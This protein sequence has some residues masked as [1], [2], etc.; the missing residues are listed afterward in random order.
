MQTRETEND[1]QGP[2]CYRNFEK[3]APG[4]Q[5]GTYSWRWTNKHMI[6]YIWTV[7]SRNSCVLNCNYLYYVYETYLLHYMLVVKFLESGSTLRDVYCS[8]IKKAAFTLQEDSL[9]SLKCKFKEEW[10][11]KN[12]LIKFV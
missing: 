5:S 3:R 10:K 1:F 12:G 11:P 8:S 4:N 9:T 6:F 2:K 7:E